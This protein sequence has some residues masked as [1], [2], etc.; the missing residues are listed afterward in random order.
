MSSFLDGWV[1]VGFEND[2][3]RCYQ[4]SVYKAPSG[5]S[6][7]RL[8]SPKGGY[9]YPIQVNVIVYAHTSFG[10]QSSDQIRS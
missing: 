6:T 4:S 7:F 5:G 2:L 8:G 10:V 9:F 3:D 1:Q